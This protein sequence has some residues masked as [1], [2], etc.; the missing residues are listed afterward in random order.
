MLF[1]SMSSNGC[2]YCEELARTTWV[3]WDVRLLSWDSGPWQDAECRSVVFDGFHNAI[4]VAADFLL[5]T[6][7]GDTDALVVIVGLFIRGLQ[8]VK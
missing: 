2:F 5:I 1:R 3:L 8:A 7:F 4:D 6:V